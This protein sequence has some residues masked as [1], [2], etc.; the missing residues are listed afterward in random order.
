MSR[1]QKV[2]LYAVL[3]LILLLA[4]AGYTA[5]RVAFVPLSTSTDAPMLYLVPGDT[6][7][8]ALAR[9]PL[10]DGDRRWLRLA[11]LIDG[12]PSV[13][14]SATLTGAYSLVPSVTPLQLVHR[15]HQ[16]RQSPVRLTFNTARTKGELAERIASSLLMSREKL[17]RLLSDSAYCARYGTDTANIQSLFLPDTYE[18]YWT[19]SPEGLVERMHEEY[20]KFWTAER[21]ARLA[22]LGLSTFEASTLASIAEEETANRSER[23]VVARLYWNRLQQGMPLQADPTV[24]FAVGD[25][26]L[27]RILLEHL[28]VKSPYNTY[29]HPGLP[30]GPIRVCEKATLDTLLASRPHNYIYMCAREDFSGLHNFTASYKEH[31]VNA[32]RYR[33]AL[34]GRGK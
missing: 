23:G 2:L 4:A 32:E 14:D 33:R 20:E 24:K 18:L 5:Y 8:A 13:A 34:D 19:I 28:Q 11:A 10:S 31:L 16:R 22:E 27:R 26:T 17:L 3:P 30:P 12:T 1:L 15:V 6:L 21:R 25:F 7:S 29:R 9:L